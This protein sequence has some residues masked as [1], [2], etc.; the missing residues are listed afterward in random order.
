MSALLSGCTEEE[1][2]AVIRF[3]WSE[4]VSGVEIYRRRTVQYGDKRLP[5]DRSI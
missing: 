3:L 1:Q 4:G 2:R 5:Q